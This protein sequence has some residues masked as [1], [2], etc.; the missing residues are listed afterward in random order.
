M[1]MRVHRMRRLGISISVYLS[2]SMG[3]A[4]WGPVRAQDFRAADNHCSS[5]LEHS[6]TRL[7]VDLLNRC[8]EA[9]EELRRGLGSQATAVV[10]L[11]VRM[12]VL[13]A[14]QRAANIDEESDRLSLLRLFPR[15]LRLVDE[16]ASQSDDR[17]HNLG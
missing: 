6:D 3:V 5:A 12:T 1:Q 4:A 14:L 9:L 10:G 8:R 13:D 16:L 15:L 7:K 11:S 2:V 17:R